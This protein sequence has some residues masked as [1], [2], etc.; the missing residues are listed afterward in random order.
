MAL[1]GFG[2]TREVAVAVGQG[3]VEGHDRLGHG[4][5]H[6]IEEEQAAVGVGIA[7]SSGD[8]ASLGVDKAAELVLR[9][10]GTS[11][12]EPQ[13]QSLGHLLTNSGLARACRTDQHHRHFSSN[14]FEHLIKLLVDK[15]GAQ[16]FLASRESDDDVLLSRLVGVLLDEGD[17]ILL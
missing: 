4:S 3:S 2:V 1:G 8:D 17:D 5:I 16:G 11:E 12:V 13:V 7:E 15:L 9:S 14:C 10:H 6:L